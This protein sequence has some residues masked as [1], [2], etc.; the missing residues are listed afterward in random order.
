MHKNLIASLVLFSALILFLISCG[1]GSGSSVTS[2]SLE[3]EATNLLP[4]ARTTI[5]AQANQEISDPYR[6]EVSFSFRTNNSGAELDVINHHLDGEGSAQAIYIAGN[7]TGV[8]VVEVSFKNDA[9]ATVSITVGYN[10]SRI[11]LEQSGSNSVIATAYNESGL[12]VPDVQLDF[13]ITAGTI[14]ASATTNQNGKA[15]VTFSLPEG[16]NTARVTASS[17][18]VSSTIDVE[19]S[20]RQRS[21]SFTQKSQWESQESTFIKLKQN[22]STVKA[23]ISDI[24]NNPVPGIPLTFTLESGVLDHEIIFTDKNGTA[25]QAFF[26]LGHQNATELIVEGGGLSAT[27]MLN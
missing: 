6:E 27:L 21:I 17:G 23:R 26:T 4:G 11:S 7:N 22:G 16:T 24:N 9:K 2:V 20:T 14:S 15:Q 18:T 3:A 10:V 12:P 1:G 19:K 5:T 8:D 13:Y 25:K